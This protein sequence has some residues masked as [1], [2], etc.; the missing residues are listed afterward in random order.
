MSFLYPVK[1]HAFGRRG[2]FAVLS[3]GGALLVCVCRMRLPLRRL[4][5]GTST[6]VSDGLGAFTL[7]TLFAVAPCEIVAR[8]EK[9]VS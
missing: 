7:H 2:G 1:D 3:G 4:L 5:I 8:R 6:L 9:T